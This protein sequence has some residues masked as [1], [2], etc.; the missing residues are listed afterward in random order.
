MARNA[1]ATSGDVWGGCCRADVSSDNDLKP[2]FYDQ[3]G[4]NH[5]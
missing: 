3:A 2:D 5:D 1:S 4:S